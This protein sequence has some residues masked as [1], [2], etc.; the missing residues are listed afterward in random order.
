[1][2]YSCPIPNRA[3]SGGVVNS[4]IEPTQWCPILAEPVGIS[5]LSLRD[6]ADRA[7]SAGGGGGWQIELAHSGGVADR[8]SPLRGCGR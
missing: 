3:H 4:Q 5:I 7:H 8:A 2:W 6:V 1:M